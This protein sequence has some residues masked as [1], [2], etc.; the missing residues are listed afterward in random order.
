MMIPTEP[1]SSSEPRKQRRRHERTKTAVEVELHLDQHATP[2]RV[3][4]ADLSLG[5]CYLEMMFTLAVGTKL[6]L[7]LWINEAELTVDAVVV[8]C[9]VQVGNGIQFSGMTAEDTA[10]L[11]QYLAVISDSPP[12]K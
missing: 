4:T 8:T 11:Q 5:G 2:L 6:K 3:K 7:A 1:D 12:A 10:R 9:D